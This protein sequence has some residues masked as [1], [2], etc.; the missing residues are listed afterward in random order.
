MTTNEKDLALEYSHILSLR[1]K[2]RKLDDA[3][4]KREKELHDMMWEIVDGRE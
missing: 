1:D 2:V 3:L 4:A